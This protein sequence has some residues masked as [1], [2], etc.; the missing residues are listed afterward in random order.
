[1]RSTNPGDI[2]GKQ[3][4]GL[5]HRYMINLSVVR[6]EKKSKTWLEAIDQGEFIRT[7]CVDYYRALLLSEAYI[8]WLFRLFFTTSQ[9]SWRRCYKASCTEDYEK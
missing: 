8:Y 2:F 6:V 9:S 1:M 3:Q 7:I 5:R 4:L